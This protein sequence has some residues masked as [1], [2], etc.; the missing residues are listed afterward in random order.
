MLGPLEN[1]DLVGTDLTL[2]IHGNVWADLDRTAGPLPYLKMRVET[3]RLGMK[4]G[5]GF[6]SWTPEQQTELRQR[7]LTQLKTL[8]QQGL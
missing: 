5:K 4:T 7:A 1:A 3:G 6:R 8:N 2:A